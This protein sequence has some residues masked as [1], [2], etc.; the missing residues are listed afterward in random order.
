MSSSITEY[1]KDC[2]ILHKQKEDEVT[3]S[4]IDSIFTKLKENLKTEEECMMFMTRC[5]DLLIRSILSERSKLSGTSL[6]LLRTLFDITKGNISNINILISSVLKICGRSNKIVCT[7]GHDSLVHICQYI[8]IGPFIKI[9][10][11]YYESANKNIR[12]A[13]IKGILAGKGNIKFERLIEKGKTDQFVEIRNLC[14]SWNKNSNANNNNIINQENNKNKVLRNQT[15]N[16]ISDK[17]ILI[18]KNVEITKTPGLI[19]HSPFKKIPKIENKLN[20]K[21]E[22]DQERNACNKISELEKQVKSINSYKSIIKKDKPVIKFIKEKKDIQDD[23]TPKKLDKYLSKY[24]NLYGNI[25]E[26]TDT[27]EQTEEMI[28]EYET[29]EVIKEYEEVG[30]QLSNLSLVEDA[31][32][33]LK[34]EYTIMNSEMGEEEE[35]FEKKEANDKV[36]IV[37]EANDNIEIIKEANDKVVIVKEANDNI[38]IIKEANDNIEII[39][40]ANDKVEIIK[41]ANDKVEIIKEAND[42]VEIIKEANDKVEIIKEA[43]DNIEIIEDYQNMSCNKENQSCSKRQS[44]SVNQN[45]FASL[46]FA[47]KDECVIYD[48]NADSPLFNPSLKEVFHSK[49]SSFKDS[50]SPKSVINT[51]VSSSFLYSKDKEESLD[52]SIVADYTKIDSVIY[53]DKNIFKTTKE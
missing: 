27:K 52:N 34:Y 5:N 45:R 46:L 3:W 9:F 16:I 26:E 50:T 21:I 38:E 41:E 15:E 30:E 31:Q 36:V 40:E 43:N 39:K 7:R 49:E 13:V 44:P 51:A 32:A 19:K 10:S 6:G 33:D 1:I 47:D 23:L 8:D 29:E 14:K 11:E 53:V 37:K 22:K 17:N 25:L 4:K 24:R 28:T 35:T 42:K 20:N 2:T 48:I 12:L 18:K